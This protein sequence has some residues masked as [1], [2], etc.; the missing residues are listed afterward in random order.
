MRLH[1]G[2]DMAAIPFSGGAPAVRSK[3]SGHPNV[4]LSA[5]WYWHEK[6]R[7]AGVWRTKENHRVRKAPQPVSEQVRNAGA[8]VIAVPERPSS[9]L[10]GAPSIS[11]AA[12]RPWR[13][14]DVTRRRVAAADRAIAAR[15]QHDESGKTEMRRN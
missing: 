4:E 7:F 3:I 11:R 1:F 8:A 15:F 6:R 10:P 5:D 14:I 2:L 12:G 13:V 9:Y